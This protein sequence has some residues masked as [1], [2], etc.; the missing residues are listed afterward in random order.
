MT[1]VLNRIQFNTGTGAPTT[2]IDVAH[3][4]GVT[5]TF[6]ILWCMGQTGTTDVLG[7]K[8]MLRSFGIAVSTSSRATVGSRSEDTPTAMVTDRHYRTDACLVE[9]TNGGVAGLLDVNALDSTNIQFIIDATWGSDVRVMGFVGA[10]TDN[11][12]I[13]EAALNTSVST[14]DI[15][16]PG[17]TCTADQGFVFFMATGLDTA[18]PVSAIDSQLCIGCATDS[19]A[20]KQ[21]VWAGG[22][23]DGAAN[24]QTLAY[25]KSGQIV[26]KYD[27]GVL[28]HDTAVSFNGFITNGFQ[29]NI[30]D[31]P[32]AALRVPYL[33]VKGG[34][35]QCGNFLTQTDTTTDITVSSLP[36]TPLGGLLVSASRA[37]STAATPTDD[38]AI[39]LGAVISD[40]VE[41][42]Q[43]AM[44]DD[45]A[46]TAVVG[47][48]FEGDACYLNLSN[49]VTLE[50]RMD[51][52]SVTG[53]GWT[54]RMDDADTAQSF[55]GFLAGMAAAA[56]ATGQ[57]TIKRWGGVPFGP[58]RRGVY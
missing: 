9:V 14:Q 40:T 31:A 47:A 49:T 37:E 3:G 19:A 51:C 28:A 8:T 10:G 42:C 25:C 33:I 30:T 2:T 22:S 26:T 53:T 1:L 15:T 55:V 56:A 57:P 52:R 18:P 5:P 20:G 39:S 4:L 13:G 48:G 29:L 34:R 46:G 43:A 16:A 12:F 44:D 58:A 38:D 50:G 41:C 17:F 32:P 23:N 21:W 11:T 6:L 7:R 27:S 24:A 54:F 35:W 45:A 36:D